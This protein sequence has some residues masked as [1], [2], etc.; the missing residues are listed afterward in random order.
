MTGSAAGLGGSAVRSRTRGPTTC[1][2]EISRASGACPGHRAAKPQR[3]EQHTDGQARIGHHGARI[4]VGDGDPVDDRVTADDGEHGHHEPPRTAAD[5]QRGDG[6]ERH[7]RRAHQ[8]QDAG[9]ELDVGRGAAEQLVITQRGLAEG[10]R[11][12]G[13]PG[14]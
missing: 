11:R 4:L 12:A 7:D 8:Q 10:Q 2:V 3:P 14:S 6:D 5:P 1:S 9:D 13:D